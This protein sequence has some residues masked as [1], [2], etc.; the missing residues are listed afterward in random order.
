MFAKESDRGDSSD[1]SDTTIKPK[2]NGRHILSLPQGFFFLE[3]SLTTAN[4]G[5]KMTVAAS[6]IIR[7][8]RVNINI[9][10]R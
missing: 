2:N 3:G 9:W 7:P 1:Y 4:V 5:P 10:E 8:P 6:C